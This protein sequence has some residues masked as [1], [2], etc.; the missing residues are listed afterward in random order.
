MPQWQRGLSLHRITLEIGGN[1]ESFRG[2]ALTM[3]RN[4]RNKVPSRSA[5]TVGVLKRKGNEAQRKTNRLMRQSRPRQA[6]PLRRK[7]SPGASDRR[8]GLLDITLVGV[9]AS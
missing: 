8:A 3:K 9:G 7:K 6:K 2:K 4:S 5:R 1:A